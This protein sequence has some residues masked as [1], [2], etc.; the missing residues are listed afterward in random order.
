SGTQLLG[1]IGSL[2]VVNFLSWRYHDPARQL[3]ERLGI[4]PKHAYYGP[5]G[6]ESPTRYLHEAAQRIA[7]GECSVAAVCG[8]EAQS[9]A[10]KAERA[11]ITPSWTPFATDVE[12]PKRGAVFQKPMAVKLGVFRPITVYPLYES[13]TSA[14]WGQTPRE[15]LAE[16]GELWSTFAGVAAQNP[17]SWLKKNFSPDQITTPSPENRLI[18]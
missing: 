13:A 10:T 18:A 15:A 12:E 7:R 14:H 6:G 11:G 1:E 8:A 3:S 4:R 16:S 2:D 5:V 9:T 17:N